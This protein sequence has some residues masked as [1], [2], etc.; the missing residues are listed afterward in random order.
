MTVSTGETPT[1]TASSSS[2]VLIEAETDEDAVT[3]SWNPYE[4]NWSNEDVAHNEAI[5]YILQFDQPGDNF[6][7]PEEVEVGS[8]LSR[9]FTHGELNA[10]MNRMEYTA[11]QE[12]EVAV[13]LFP[14]LGDNQTPT[15]SDVVTISITP[16][17]DKP[18]FATIYMVGDATASNWD[19]MNGMPMFRSEA[20]PFVF[21]YTGFLESG[22]LKFLQNPGQWAPQWGSD[23]TATGVAFRA[24]ED[25]ADP[26]TFNV[27]A[28][29]YYTVN[30]DIRKMTFS[31]APYDAAG[32]PT[33][34][35]IGIIGG[36][37]DW[38][39]IAP[40]TKSSFNPHLWSMDYSFAQST[41]LKFRIAEGWSMNWG[42]GN[43]SSDIYGRGSLN[44][45]NIAVAAGNYRIIFNDLTGDY[46]F[47][48]Q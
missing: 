30:L 41:E 39:D 13:R 28:N 35:S 26:G 25:D 44:S 15:Y 6:E 46:V 10:L 32:A 16:W 47:I 7:S 4:L 9:T 20:D 17:L 42:A 1:L 21:T 48:K 27:P 36:F 38:A 8:D 40:M 2:V 5:N 31:L 23:G 29:G 18:K 19:A 14:L 11:G 22:A 24:T 34:S 37:N 33:Y 12:G 45:P 43:N 3:F